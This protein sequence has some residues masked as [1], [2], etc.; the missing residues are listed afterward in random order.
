MKKKTLVIG[1]STNPSRYSFLAIN[2]LQEHGHS[3]FALG[4]KSGKVG[5]VEI[6]TDHKYFSDIHTVTL[7]VGPSHQENIREYVISLKP[8][9]VIF[10]PGTEDLHFQSMLKNAG[11][12]FEEACTL[13]MLGTGQY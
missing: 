5:D 9:R 7:Y 2:R 8:Q 13:V 3:V 1:A 10:N 12:P 11:I 4:L 6:F